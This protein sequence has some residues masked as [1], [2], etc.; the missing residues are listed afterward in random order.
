MEFFEANNRWLI[1]T[2]YVIDESLTL[3]QA[4]RAGD[5][6]R[7]LAKDFFGHAICQIH[8]VTPSDVLRAWQIFASH[9]DKDWSFTDCVSKAVMEHLGITKALAFDKHFRQFGGIE[10]VP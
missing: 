1:T 2:D 10:V 6:A 9:D 5:R 8:W 7:K 4:R 3:I